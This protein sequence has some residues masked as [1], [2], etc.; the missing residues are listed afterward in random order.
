MNTRKTVYNKLFKDET[1]LA[2]HNVELAVIDDIKKQQESLTKRYLS[3][4]DKIAKIRTDIKTIISNI[5]A[6]NSETE[7]S[8][9]ASIDLMKKIDELGVQIPNDLNSSTKILFNQKDTAKTLIKDLN[10]AINSLT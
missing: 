8:Y 1:K 3:E 2:S 10:N 4:M 9:Q 5:S 6:L 7:K